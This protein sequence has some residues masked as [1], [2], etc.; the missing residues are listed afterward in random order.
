M[1]ACTHATEMDPDPAARPAIDRQAFA[2]LARQHH[3]SLLAYARALVGNEA[4]SADIVQDAFVAAWRSL[5]RFDVTRDFGAWMRGIVR[6]KWRE[7]LR[8]NSREVDVD[9]QTLETWENLFA[10]WDGNRQQQATGDLFDSLDDCLRR[11]PD[12]M[13]QPIRR[14]YYHDESGDQLASA[15]GI[16]PPTL[17]KRL[18]RARQLLRD[19]LDQKLP[20]TA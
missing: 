1:N 12:T 13:R 14:F 20:T 9:D 6:N 7:L 8:R 4:S 18:Q 15:L 19:C 16:A 11:L 17:R 2:D 3:R 5:G 10:A